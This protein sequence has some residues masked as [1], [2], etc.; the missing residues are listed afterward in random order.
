MTPRLR[1]AVGL[2]AYQAVIL[3]LLLYGWGFDDLRGF[4]LEPAR[5][6]LIALMW[7]GVVIA[8][9]R[10]PNLD[11]FRKGKQ[12]VGRWQVG[13]LTVVFLVVWWFLPFGDRRGLW[14]T[15]NFSLPRY[16]GLGLVIAGSWLRFA[17][18]RALGK[19]FS[20]YVTLQEDHQLIQSGIYGVIR[21][22][23]YLGLLLFLPGF[24]LVFR[25]WL[26]VPVF[27]GIAVFV[28]MRI[29]QEEALL[30]HHFGGEFE[31]YRSHTWRLVPFIY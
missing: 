10:F 31:A 25:S 21:H 7:I 4:F 8:L 30:L 9:V 2:L 23:M 29:R 18:R 3:C 24:A 28:A 17:G 27:V 13:V 6:G 14:V 1:A 11:F 15:G 19:Q 26:A 22:P 20:A 12:S 16:V 5:T